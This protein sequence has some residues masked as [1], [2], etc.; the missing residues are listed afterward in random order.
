LVGGEP[1]A[2]DPDGKDPYFEPAHEFA[3]KFSDAGI[4]LEGKTNFIARLNSN[5]KWR[6]S[7]IRFYADPEVKGSMISTEVHAGN[8]MQKEE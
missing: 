4:T 8:E 6:P 1:E 3:P 5:V 7:H 2:L